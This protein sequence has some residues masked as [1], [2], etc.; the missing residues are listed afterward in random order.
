L[1]F[2]ARYISDNAVA[3]KLAAEADRSLERGADAWHCAAGAAWPIRALIDRGQGSQGA[4]F[5]RRAVTAARQ[6]ENPVPRVDALFLLVTASWPIGGPT[7][8]EAIAQLVASATATPT[9]KPQSVLRDL[10]LMLANEGRDFTAVL[11]AI[12][13]GKARRQAERRLS[14][15]E[16]MAPRPWGWE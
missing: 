11:S 9:L 12:P 14:A 2:V 6:I 10:C 16:F 13:E 1:A 15:K 3:V 8:Q 5:M 7:W 4:P